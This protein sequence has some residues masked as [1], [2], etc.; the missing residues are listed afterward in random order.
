MFP[1]I[2]QETAADCI[3][4]KGESYVLNLNIFAFSSKNDLENNNRQLLFQTFFL[5]RWWEK[6]KWLLSWRWIYA[7]NSKDQE[8]LMTFLGRYFPTFISK[9][10]ML[11]HSLHQAIHRQMRKVWP[12]SPKLSTN[13][14]YRTDHPQARLVLEHTH[15]V[16]QNQY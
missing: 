3:F 8:F 4:H 9:T 14:F 1:W 6:L 12:V 5:S 10:S 2:V 7:K 15:V 16:L 11:Q 13:F